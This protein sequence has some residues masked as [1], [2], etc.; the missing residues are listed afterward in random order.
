MTYARSA[1]ILHIPHSSAYIPSYDHYINNNIADEQ[2]KVTTDW[3]TDE[4][5]NLP[6]VNSIITPFSRVFCDVE[7]LPDEDEPMYKK[8]A[9]FYYT[10]TDDGQPLRHEDSAH[11]AEVW[12]KYHQVHQQKLSELVIEKLAQ[13]ENVLII[14]CHSFSSEPLSREFNTSPQRPEI[15]IGTDSFHTPTSLKTIFNDAFQ[16]LGFS[17]KENMP[18]SGTM[19]PLEHYK[20]EVRV[21]SIMIEI[22]KKLYMDEEKYQVFHDKVAELREKVQSVVDSVSS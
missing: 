9:G 22:N 15:C 3:A 19:V 18:Y 7:R 8:G 13:H 2:V 16:D 17:V 20:K 10:K 21:H 6:E 4:I 5:F 12:E 14:D 11:K 1:L